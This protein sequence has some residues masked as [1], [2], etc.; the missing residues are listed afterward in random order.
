M[1]NSKERIKRFAMIFLAFVMVAGNVLACTL[2]GGIGEG[3]T[4][5]Q[6]IPVET[7]GTTPSEAGVPE[8]NGGETKPGLNLRLSDGQSIP[9]VIE[10]LVPV[11]GTTLTQEEI[12]SILARLT[13]WVEDQGLGV[14]FRLPEEVLPPP[15]TGETIP[16]TFPTTAELRGPQPVYGEELEV[17][18]FAPDG[19]VVIAPF[20]SVTFNQPM[21]ALTLLKRWLKKMSLFR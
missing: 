5:P 7:N 20:I 8:E 14:D 3:P 19:E 21:V 1:T 15:L 16:E 6:P 4:T 9:S 13:P 11:L 2:P 18:R 17:L 10:G 12:N